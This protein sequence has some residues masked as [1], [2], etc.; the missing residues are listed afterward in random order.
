LSSASVAL[1]TVAGLLILAP[2]AVPNAASPRPELQTDVGQS[3]PRPHVPPG[4]AGNLSQPDVTPPAL[5]PKQQR[6]LMKSSY[7]KMKQQVDELA[8]LAKSL[9]DQVNKSNENILSLQMVDTADKIEK[10]AKKIKD[11]ARGH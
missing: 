9:Q 7:E 10:L 11:S 5:T 3:E 2:R 8:G 6:D 4:P 1:A